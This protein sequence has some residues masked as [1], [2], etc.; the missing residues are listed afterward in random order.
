MPFSSGACFYQ[1]NVHRFF[2]AYCEFLL[3]V[4]RRKKHKVT[5]LFILEKNTIWFFMLLQRN[6]FLL[7]PKMVFWWGV[8]TKKFCFQTVANEICANWP[9]YWFPFPLK[10]CKILGSTYKWEWIPL[11]ISVE[12]KRNLCTHYNLLRCQ[13]QRGY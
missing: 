3:F 7:Y 6:I 12:K 4:L 9:M 5:S 2:I 8:S 1:Q 10:R 11:C 13:R